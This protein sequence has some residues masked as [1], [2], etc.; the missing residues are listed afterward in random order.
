MTALSAPLHAHAAKRATALRCRPLV[1]SASALSQ[2]AWTSELAL[3]EWVSVCS[4]LGGGEATLLLRKGG[5]RERGFRLEATRCALLGTAFHGAADALA[6]RLA[7]RHREVQGVT[8]G[9]DATLLHLAE[10]TGAWATSEAEAASEVTAPWHAWRPASLLSTR[11]SWRPG[12]AVTLVELRVW[13]L[14]EPVLLRGAPE[15]GGCKSWVSGVPLTIDWDSL[16]PA[17]DEAA[18]AEAQAGLRLALQSLPDLIPIPL[19]RLE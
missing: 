7:E 14:A 3:K 11:L 1:R 17:L 19:P 13:R 9:E 12:D 4:A 5:I 18:W 8:P 2:P 15:H 16:T 6:H 10:V